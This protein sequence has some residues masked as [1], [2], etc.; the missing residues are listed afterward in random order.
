LTG[1]GVNKDYFLGGRPLA[2][3]FSVFFCLLN[4]RV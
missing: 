2:N 3:G 4:I 1:A